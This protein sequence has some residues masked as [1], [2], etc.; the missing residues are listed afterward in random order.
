M[1]ELYATKIQCLSY[2]EWEMYKL[3]KHSRGKIQFLSDTA[4]G[5]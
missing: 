1:S 2:K 5:M 3:H 4:G